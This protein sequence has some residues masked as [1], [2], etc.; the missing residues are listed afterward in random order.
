MTRHVFDRL[1]VRRIVHQLVKAL[2][3]FIL[4][5]LLA[6][7]CIVGDKVRDAR[8]RAEANRSM[9]NYQPY[10]A[11]EILIEQMAEHHKML[12][13]QNTGHELLGKRARGAE[14]LGAQFVLCFVCNFCFD[15]Q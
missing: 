11:V 2:L 12:L 8:R 13:R 6:F 3:H 7:C 9:Y 4:F 15:I 14:V 5:V 1:P 10:S